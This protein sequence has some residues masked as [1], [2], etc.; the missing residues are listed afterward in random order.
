MCKVHLLQS[1]S[2]GQPYPQPRLRDKHYPARVFRLTLLVYKSKIKYILVFDYFYY[3]YFFM[4]T[5]DVSVIVVSHARPKELRQVLTSLY[6]QTLR[7]VEI[8]IVDNRSTSSP[9][10]KNI[11]QQFRGTKLL[12]NDENIGFARAINQGIHVAVGEYLYLSVDDVLLERECLEQFLMFHRSHSEV[13]LLSGI[14]YYARDPHTI[15]C[16]GGELKLSRIY[17]LKFNYFC[18]RDTG[19]IKEPFHV[20]FILGGITFAP[21][22]LLLQIGGFREDFYMYFEDAELSIRVKRLGYSLMVLPKAKLY[23]IIAPSN[24]QEN[25]IG[26]QKIRNLLALYLLHA[27]LRWLPIFYMGHL[28]FYTRNALRTGIGK[29]SICWQ[30]WRA[31]LYTV[32]HLLGDRYRFWRLRQRAGQNAPSERI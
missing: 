18:E 29:S 11:V 12:Q 23:D 31:F 30:A 3:Y 10:I 7:D 17:Q 16:A 19:Q 26:Q 6:E 4:K 22:N 1:K 27:Q 25:F 15:E 9:E 14:L 5:P 24:L 13:G 28:F 8:I 20:T 2:S 32:P 21:R